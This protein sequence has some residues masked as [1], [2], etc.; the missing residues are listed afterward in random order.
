ML[1]R[2]KRA[3]SYECFVNDLR[4]CEALGL[5]YSFV[6]FWRLEITTLGR[7]TPREL[8]CEVQARW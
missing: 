5:K 2:A 1:C 4:Q 8:A 3:K 7:H 6:P